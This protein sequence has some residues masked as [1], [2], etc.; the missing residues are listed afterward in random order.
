MIYLLSAIGFTPGGSGTVHIYIQTVNRTTQLTTLVGKLC[1]I[2]TQIGQTNW[3]ECGPCPV[4]ESYTLEFALQLRKSTEKPYLTVP[5]LPVNAKRAAYAVNT[6]DMAAFNILCDT[7]C[8][9][10]ASTRM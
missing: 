7:V 6:T 9:L 2:R 10:A 8:P 5:Y 1:G 4:F 3:E